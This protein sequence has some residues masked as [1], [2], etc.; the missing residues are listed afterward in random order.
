LIFKEILAQPSSGDGIAERST[1]AKRDTV[2]QI[3]R[4]DGIG[5]KEIVWN[6]R[7]WHL[8]RSLKRVDLKTVD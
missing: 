3:F 1:S 7:W 5:A 8:F 6:H 2:N 4:A